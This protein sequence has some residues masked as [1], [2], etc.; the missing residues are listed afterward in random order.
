MGPY[1]AKRALFRSGHFHTESSPKLTQNGWYPKKGVLQIRVPKWSGARK[2]P[3]WGTPKWPILTPFG[4]LLGPLRTPILTPFGPYRRETIP[5]ALH[6]LVD[7]LSCLTQACRP[8]Q[9]PYTGL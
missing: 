7:P 4:P 9:L 5:P 2:V 8:P 3:F 1:R 6:R